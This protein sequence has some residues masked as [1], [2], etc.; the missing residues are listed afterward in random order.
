M[1]TACERHQ[2]S[3]SHLVVYDNDWLPAKPNLSNFANPSRQQ[4]YGNSVCMCGRVFVC[5]VCR[6]SAA[7]FDVCFFFILLLSFCA[8]HGFAAGVK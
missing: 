4:L 8:T 5:L 6:V 7:T 3:S 2:N 1:Q